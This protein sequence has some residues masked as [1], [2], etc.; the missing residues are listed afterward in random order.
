MITTTMLE[1]A[2]PVYHFHQVHQRLIHAGQAQVWETLSTLTPDQLTLTTPLLALRHLG[3]PPSPKRPL[4]TDGPVRILAVDSPRYALGAAIGQPWRLNP[5]RREVTSLSEFT[6]FDEPGWT[7]YLTDFRLRTSDAGVLL[8][9]E[10]RG[11]STDQHARRRFALY[12][13]AIRTGSSLV[14][15]DIL[16]TVA[17]LSEVHPPSATGSGRAHQLGRALRLDGSTQ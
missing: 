6:E 12:W 5:P 10:T 13:A 16:A 11:Y 17:R 8:S 7:K 1:Q 3:R 15:H 2:M 4:F 14:R 9:T